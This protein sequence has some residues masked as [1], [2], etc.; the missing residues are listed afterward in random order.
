LVRNYVADVW[1][2]KGEEGGSLDEMN[3]INNEY[4]RWRQMW[5]KHGSDVL[6]KT[7]QQAKE[8]RQNIRDLECEECETY[9]QNVLN[10][11][12]LDGTGEEVKPSSS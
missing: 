10:V 2:D 7:S 3:E 12:N 5:K 1:M 8:F 9:R 11:L 6:N 4:K